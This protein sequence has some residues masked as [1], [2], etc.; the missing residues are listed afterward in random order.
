MPRLLALVFSPRLAGL[1]VLAVLIL[2]VVLAGLV[3]EASVGSTVLAVLG[4]AAAYV[5]VY[6]ISRQ[7]GARASATL[8]EVLR[9]EG[10]KQMA[11]ARPDQQASMEEMKKQFDASLDL[12]RRS[13][14]GRGALTSMPLYVIIGPSGSG[15]STMLRESGISFPYMT[16]SRSA[17]R[18]LGGTA[19]CDWWFADRGILLDTAGR[20]ATELEDREEWL[21]FLKQLRRSR[22]GHPISGAVVTFS[23]GDILEAAEPDLQRYVDSIRDRLDE[24]TRELGAIFPVYV[25]FTKCDRIHGF[26]ETFDTLNKDQRKQVWGFTFPFQRGKEFSVEGEFLG[27]FDELYRVLTARRIELL[28]ADARPKRR[29]QAY[30]FP[31]QFARARERLRGF[32]GLLQQANPYQEGALLR[33][34]Y[35]T[36]GTQEG[37]TIDRI[38][39]WAQPADLGS[40]VPA[41][42]RKCYFVD[43]LF[44]EV[45]FADADL[46]TPTERARRARKIA[47]TAVLGGLLCAMLLAVV[48]GWGSYRAH[49]DRFG[50]VQKAVEAEDYPAKLRG[51]TAALELLESPSDVSLLRRGGV[52]ENLRLRCAGFSHEILG[53]FADK[54]KNEIIAYNAKLPKPFQGNDSEPARLMDW[55]ESATAA[56]TDVTSKLTDLQNRYSEFFQRDLDKTSSLYSL[57][58]L[59]MDG[60]DQLA[61]VWHRD[62][63]GRK[64]TKFLVSVEFESATKNA[65]DRKEEIDRCYA[66]AMNKMSSRKFSD[67]FPKSVAE[68]DG[69]SPD[70]L[71]DFADPDKASSKKNAMFLLEQKSLQAWGDGAIL[72][73]AW[74]QKVDGWISEAQNHLKAQ[75]AKQW[76]KEIQRRQDR[77][78]SASKACDDLL[79]ADRAL[80]EYL[81][82]RSIYFPPNPPTNAGLATASNRFKGVCEKIDA[83]A[84]LPSCSA[85][86][87]LEDAIK[88]VRGVSEALKEV[89]KAIDGVSMLV[90][91][92]DAKDIETDLT[93]LEGVARKK[94]LLLAIARGCGVAISGINVVKQGWL[95]RSSLYP[96]A[97][98]AT[99]DCKLKELGQVTEA[100]QE[101]DEILRKFPGGD[102]F[103]LTEDWKAF[104]SGTKALQDCFPGSWA[105]DGS[106]R[107][108]ADNDVEVSMKWAGTQV[109]NKSFQASAQWEWKDEQG[110]FIQLGVKAKSYAYSLQHVW[111]QGAYLEGWTANN[112]QV[113]LSGSFALVRLFRS[114]ELLSGDELQKAIAD[115]GAGATSKKKTLIS[116]VTLRNLDNH[117]K[118]ASFWLVVGTDV[119]ALFEGTLIVPKWP[120]VVWNIK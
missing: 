11:G 68:F 55:R 116:K 95:S 15:K 50:A 83:V 115:L 39:H 88:N 13:R 106:V 74:H 113:S 90:V 87:S 119:P 4:V 109:S 103:T 10:T 52:A 26:V 77:L 91:P 94:A 29:V 6:L 60:S 108:R 59:T 20:W 101:I 48:L 65:R 46:A 89:S 120:D 28:T 37:T 24:L 53:K 35:F 34:V 64:G 114:G 9:A 32:V 79:C 92:E 111:K 57:W 104:A 3:A 110:A 78:G 54:V 102:A 97:P 98:N 72:G 107:I 75:L 18:G 61:D 38:L 27:R 71:P 93:E 17:L 45:V 63:R 16:K 1:F 19:N 7:R 43:D 36:S 44:G 49:S 25:V 62:L 21:A 73:D 30:V 66:D 5:S 100:I 33:G 40:A 96:L 67:W 118:T 51:F 42:A 2:A 23:L 14:L 86:S 58:K 47:R 56:V 12:L 112:E 99:K 80:S 41:E 31:L 105:V 76:R 84:R 117:H 85:G 81:L 8:E 82:V 70:A 69:I 22:G